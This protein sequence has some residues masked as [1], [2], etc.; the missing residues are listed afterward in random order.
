MSDIA[1]TDNLLSQYIADSASLTE[2]ELA[3]VE[4][5]LEQ[6][7]EEDAIMQHILAAIDDEDSFAEFANISNVVEITRCTSADARAREL[8]V[9]IME[10]CSEE[11]LFAR[12]ERECAEQRDEQP[13]TLDFD[14]ID[15][16]VAD[17]AVQKLSNQ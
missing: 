5:Y 3:A 11:E 12:F 8:I 14:N 13:L 1:I 2:E 4:R 15:F 6:S 9:D 10:E 7:P 16:A 17:E